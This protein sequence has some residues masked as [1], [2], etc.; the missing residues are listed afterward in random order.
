MFLFRKLARNMQMQLEELGANKLY[1]N[2]VLIK[3]F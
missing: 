2:I 3:K 1:N